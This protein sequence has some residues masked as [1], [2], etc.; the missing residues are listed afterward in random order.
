MF[1]VKHLEEETIAA[2]ATPQGE[3]G[4]G[5]VRISG[6]AA[7]KIY[8]KVF[9]PSKNEPIKTHKMIHGWLI[10]KKKKVDQVLACYMKTPKSFTGEDV[11]EIFCHGGSAITKEVLKTILSAGARLAKRGEFS[12]RAFLNGKIDL[13]QAEAVLD[14]V[15][16]KSSAGAG[17]ALKQLEGKLS[18]KVEKIRKLLI[19]ILA[20]IEAVIDFE[21]DVGELKRGALRKKIGK[22]EKE[23]KRLLDSYGQGR[24]YRNGIATVIIGKPNVG[25][26]SLLNALLGEERAIVTA[27]PGTTR[28]SIEES[29]NIDGVQ[30]R[31]VDTAGIR[32]PKDEAEKF[33]VL[34]TEK[35]LEEAEFAIVVLDGSKKINREDRM[36]ISKVKEWGRRAV[37]VINKNDKKAE[38]SKAGL[39]SYGSIY[40]VSAKTGQGMGALL[41]GI[42]RAISKIGDNSLITD[43]YINGR[44]KECLKGAETALNRA[45]EASVKGYSADIIAIDIK[46]AII[47]LGEITG[48]IVSDEV[49][50]K[51]FSEFCV[52]K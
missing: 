6:N 40:C 29:L 48:E 22:I 5:V 42:G 52:G 3:G 30:L 8:K 27:S 2:I 12:K 41:K 11:V 50:N 20:E 49:I 32:H 10:N 14:L 19:E 17:L 31:I 37:V 43:T 18:E 15:K 47:S 45:K 36:V 1:H 38:L 21:E 26:S 44:H 24:V 34:R 51:V 35:E 16:A 28:D 4:V 39:K 25:K 33:G 9:K 23:I 7:K 46:D 13:V